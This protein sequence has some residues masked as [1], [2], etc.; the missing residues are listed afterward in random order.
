MIDTTD[1][2]GSAAVSG[3]QQWLDSVVEDVVDPD[4]PIIDTHHHRQP[5]ATRCFAAPPPACTASPPD[6]AAPTTPR[7]PRFVSAQTGGVA[8]C[9]DTNFGVKVCVSTYQWRCGLC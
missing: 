5:S 6:I 3:S 8:V 7:P 9:A 4:V 2:A 1:E